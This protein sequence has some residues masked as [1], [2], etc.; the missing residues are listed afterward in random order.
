VFY[1][2]YLPLKKIAKLHFFPSPISYN[3]KGY[4]KK[5]YFR[6]VIANQKSTRQTI[7][8]AK[9]QREGF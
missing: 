5:G 4:F 3:K 6:Y 1:S 8:Q 7:I 2:K 9:I